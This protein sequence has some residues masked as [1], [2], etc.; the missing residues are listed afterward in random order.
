MEENV[1]LLTLKAKYQN[2]QNK[3]KKRH[4]FQ[5][6]EIFQAQGISKYFLT[7][8]KKHTVGKVKKI[9]QFRPLIFA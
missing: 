7:S 6:V 5:V 3:L 1:F 9:V 8:T 4:M 2:D